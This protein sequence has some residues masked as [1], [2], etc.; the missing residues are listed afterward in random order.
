MSV[1]TTDASF[2]PYKPGESLNRSRFKVTL[3]DDRSTYSPYLAYYQSDFG[4]RSYLELYS[5][6]LQAS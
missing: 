6:I 1:H 3:H 5:Y 4:S 2:M